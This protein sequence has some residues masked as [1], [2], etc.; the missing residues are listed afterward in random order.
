MHQQISQDA[1]PAFSEGGLR[2]TDHPPAEVSDLA[3]GIKV[4]DF[5][6]GPHGKSPVDAEAFLYHP[7]FKQM[8]KQ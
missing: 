8:Q 4:A 2:P 6:P 7:V 3:L 1:I 5:R